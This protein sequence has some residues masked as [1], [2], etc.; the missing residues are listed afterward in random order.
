MTKASLAS[1]S[2]KEINLHQKYGFFGPP[3]WPAWVDF[4]V[5]LFLRTSLMT[6]D[7]QSV[8][9]SEF[10]KCHRS[11]INS[12]WPAHFQ[13]TDFRAKRDR[14]FVDP[15]AQLER[16]K[17]PQHDLLK[18]YWGVSR[19]LLLHSWFVSLTIISFPP[20]LLLVHFFLLACCNFQAL[21]K[22]CDRYDIE[23]RKNTSETNG[24]C[25]NGELSKLMVFHG[26]FSAPCVASYRISL[27][28]TAVYFMHVLFLR[29]HP[30]SKQYIAKMEEVRLDWRSG[31]CALMGGMLDRKCVW[32]CAGECSRAFLSAFAESLVNKSMSL[33]TTWKTVRWMPVS[34][35]CPRLFWHQRLQR[36]MVWRHSKF[37]ERL[38]GCKLLWKT[39]QSTVN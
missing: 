27:Q 15:V 20:R 31:S 34:R 22:Q 30:Q 36:S 32:E 33:F 21:Q 25:V 35:L 6:I 7:D 10:C 12:W 13:P 5:S 24:M 39:N 11:I 4:F 26:S 1:F 14:V 29:M 3:G 37:I 38:R 9:F 18:C 28:L 16:S 17:D 23:Q 19:S 2:S 8:E